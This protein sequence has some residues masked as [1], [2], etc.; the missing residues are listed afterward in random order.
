M[1]TH[2]L[3]SA[4]MSEKAFSQAY[5]LITRMPLRI[6]FIT[7][8]RLSVRFAISRLNF[9]DFVLRIGPAVAHL[10]GEE[11]LNGNKEENGAKAGQGGHSD[12]LPQQ[13]GIGD[14]DEGSNPDLMEEAE[15]LEFSCDQTVTQF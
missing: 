15:H 13:I 4:T 2:R 11:A 3:S 12:F 9:L 6:S 7:L 8:I 1:Q 5:I 10:L 14:E